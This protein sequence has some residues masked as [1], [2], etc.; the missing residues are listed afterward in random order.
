M[1]NVERF[2][3]LL[4]QNLSGLMNFTPFTV[5]QMGDESVRVQFVWFKHPSDVEPSGVNC[6]WFN[7]DQ[8]VSVD[9]M[10]DFNFDLTVMSCILKAALHC[11]E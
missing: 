11:W 3:W 10:G 8:T 6:V 5:E 7:K 9:T 4:N 1:L 2:R